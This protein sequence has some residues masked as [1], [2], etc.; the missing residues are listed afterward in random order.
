M[1][2]SSPT[3][4]RCENERR[5]VHGKQGTTMQQDEMQSSR[6]GFV[7]ASLMGGLAVAM[8]GATAQGQGRSLK[9]EATIRANNGITT[10]INVFTV[11]ADNHQQLLTVLR[12]GVETFFSKMPGFISSSVH[13]GRDGRQVVNYSQWRS[14]ADVAGFRRHPDFEPYIARLLPLAKAETIECDV[15]WMG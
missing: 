13:D 15:V 4:H 1:D 11:E 6:R 5:P 8:Q 3:W 2:S 12:E 9:K 14:D 7:A 10:L